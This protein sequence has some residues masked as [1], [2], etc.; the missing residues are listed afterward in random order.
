ME[1]IEAGFMTKD[2]AGINRIFDE[3]LEEVSRGTNSDGVIAQ[4]PSFQ[5]LKSSLYRRERLP[6]IPCSRADLQ[7]TG[8]WTKTLDGEEF[9]LADND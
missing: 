2:L 5:S 6:P 4:L 7:L 3:A 8:D 1:T 9:I